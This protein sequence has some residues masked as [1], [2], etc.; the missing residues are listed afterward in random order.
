MEVILLLRIENGR[1]KFYQWD[2]NQRLIV[3]HDNVLDVHFSNAVTSPA[4]VCEVYEENGERYV[5]VPNILLQQPWAIQAYGCCEINVRTEATFEVVRRER[6]ADYV[7]TETEVKKYSDLDK[8]IDE[9]EKVVA[10]LPKVPTIPDQLPNPQPIVLNV[11]GE[12]HEYDGSERVELNISEP[13]GG[14]LRVTMTGPEN[15]ITIDKTFEEILEAVESG[16]Y[17]D[18]FHPSNARL[19]KLKRFSEGQVSFEYLEALPQINTVGVYRTVNINK[20][21][22]IWNLETKTKTLTIKVNGEKY[23]YWGGTSV[24]VD[25]PAPPSEESIHALVQSEVDKVTDEFPTDEHIRELAREEM[26]EVPDDTHIAE[27]AKTQVTWENIPDKPFGAGEVIL[28][29]TVLNVDADS[30]MAY[31]TPEMN[32]E[33]GKTYTVTWNGVKYECTAVE[34][35]LDGMM[36]V[37]VGNLGVMTEGGEPG[38]E[39]FVVGALPAEVAA[40]MRIGGVAMSLDGSV[41]PM[42][43]IEGGGVKTLDPIYLPDVVALKTDIPDVTGYATMEAVEAKGYQTEAQVQ[44][45]ITT[46]LGVIENG[47]Y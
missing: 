35:E 6:P 30:G 27:V 22:T 4:L 17:V 16:K 18:L 20:D 21:G 1:T 32:L 12:A 3:E 14:A 31:V 7:Y 9:V 15:N 29:L 23:E 43:V 37:W 36:C 11:N 19:Y 25:I 26:P 28:P 40:E 46:A 13:S 8:R 42:L 47:T 45:L 38:P 41:N 34:Q 33:V 24:E 39:P 5:N 2:T 44:D 10:E